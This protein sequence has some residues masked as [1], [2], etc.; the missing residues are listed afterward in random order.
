[1]LKSQNL[2][3]FLVVL[4]EQLQS[5][6][7]LWGVIPSAFDTSLGDRRVVRPTS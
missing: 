2:G 6:E 4:F 7:S 1:M 3:Q 5:A